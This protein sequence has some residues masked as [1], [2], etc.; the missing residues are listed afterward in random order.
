VEINIPSAE[1][2]KRDKFEAFACEIDVYT[3][4]VFPL[5]LIG[6]TQKANMNQLYTVRLKMKTGDKQTP[7]PGMAVMVTIQYQSEKS[8]LVYIPYSALFEINSVSSVW[9]YNPDT[10]SV[11]VRKVKLYEIRTN[12]TVI[13]SEGL[14]HGEI[15]ITAGV[16][17]LKDGE[18]V[19]I[20]PQPSE[21][22]IGGL[23]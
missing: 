14:T 10:K 19:K 11:S 4:T 13:I 16:H 15:V 1:Y 17:S 3:D 20:L 23:L 8:E 22:N 21:T 2:I 6:I 5:E 18:K 9:I 12:G 7:S